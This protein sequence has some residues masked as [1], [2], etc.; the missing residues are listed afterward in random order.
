MAVQYGLT[1]EQKGNVVSHKI[2]YIPT[3]WPSYFTPSYLSKINENIGP[4]KDIQ[5]R[6]K[7]VMICSLKGTSLRTKNKPTHLHATIKMNVEK[8]Y[9]EKKTDIKSTHCVIP[10]IQS[11]RITCINL[12]WKNMNGGY[13]ESGAKEIINWKGPQGKFLVREMFCNLRKLWVIQLYP[14]VKIVQLRFVPPNVY[15]FYH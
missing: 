9:T 7:Q 8:Y 11:S 13:L 6:D 14:F 15:K 5:K 10:F 3:L 1:T 4:Q 2:K 12:S